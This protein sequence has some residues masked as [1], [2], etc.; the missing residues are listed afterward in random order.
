MPQLKYIAQRA[1]RKKINLLK[2]SAKATFPISK[3]F[4]KSP[5]KI[6]LKT[7]KRYVSDVIPI[8]ILTA[9]G[10]GKK[11]AITGAIKKIS[12]ESIMIFADVQVK[13]AEHLIK[14][15]LKDTVSEAVAKKADA[16]I[17]TGKWTGDPPTIED[18]LEAKK[19]AK[20]IPV[21]LGSGITSKNVKRYNVDGLI[22]GSYF[23][24]DGDPKE[25]D[26]HNIFPWKVKM[27]K[28][29]IERFMQSIG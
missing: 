25:K 23:K 9:F 3:C 24:G 20:N 29:R 5:T 21:I 6:V 7:V 28:K 18:V 27:Q 1:S 13:H 4:W 16:I 26:F 17:I 10:Y 12:A 2:K 22:V 14:R 8:P 15:P 11:I 19:A